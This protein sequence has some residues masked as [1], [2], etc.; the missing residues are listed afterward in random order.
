VKPLERRFFANVSK[1]GLVPEARPK[2]SK[3]SAA[4]LSRQRLGLQQIVK[5]IVSH[6]SEASQRMSNR[7]PSFVLALELARSQPLV[8]ELVLESDDACS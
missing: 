8:L 2:R 6:A 1:A 7:P 5:V 4:L 3:A